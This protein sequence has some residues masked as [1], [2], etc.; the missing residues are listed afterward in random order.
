MLM[1]IAY[2]LQ[3]SKINIDSYD[4]LIFNF[5]I[6]INREIMMIPFAVTGFSLSNF[7]IINNLKPYKNNIIIF[8]TII[9]VFIDYFTVFA[10]LY[11]YLGIRLNISSICLFFTFSLLSLER[12]KK[13]YIKQI[14][15]YVT[16]YTAGIYYLHTSVDYYLRYYILFCRK[17]TLEGLF[18]IYF[19]TYSICHFGTLIF[20]KSKAKYLFS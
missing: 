3:Y 11:D 9:F 16:R 1:I 18:I 5:K 6:V 17:G 13:K 15:E 2:F 19:V 14:L 10:E 8:S 20:G 12:I 4:N 7:N